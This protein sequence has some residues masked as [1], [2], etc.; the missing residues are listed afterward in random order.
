MDRLLVRLLFLQRSHR[1]F[2]SQT[3]G[4]GHRWRYVGRGSLRELLLWMGRIR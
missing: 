2:G 4:R 1:E 3:R